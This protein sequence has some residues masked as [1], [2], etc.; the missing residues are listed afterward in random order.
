M[1]W[2]DIDLGE[3]MNLGQVLGSATFMKCLIGFL[4]CGALGYFGIEMKD[5]KKRP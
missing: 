1:F 4:V 2:S 5:K 3:M